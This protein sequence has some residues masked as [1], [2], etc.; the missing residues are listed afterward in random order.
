MRRQSLTLSPSEFATVETTSPVVSTF[1]GLDQLLRL[2][3]VVEGELV[4]VRPDAD[5]VHF[6][7]AF[8][9]DVGF[10]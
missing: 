10:Q 7:L 9:A 3:V 1:V 2:N 8:V 4:G 6:V 5:R